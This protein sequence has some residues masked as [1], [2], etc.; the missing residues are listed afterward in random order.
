MLRGVRRRWW[1][2][3]FLTTLF[4]GFL[5][6]AW[7]ALAIHSATVN[8]S[9]GV[10]RV[11]ATSGHANVVVTLPFDPEQFHSEFFQ[12]C[13][14]VARVEGRRFYISDASRSQVHHIAAQYWIEDVQLWQRR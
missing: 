7:Q 10:K 11:L 3:P 1:F 8:E 9:A 6:L 14:T 12:H 13:C 5:A 4:I 2:G